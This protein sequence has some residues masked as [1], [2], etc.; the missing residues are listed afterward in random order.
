MEEKGR[1]IENGK[2]G[3]GGGGGEVDISVHPHPPYYSINLQFTSLNDS[4]IEK[5]NGP[6]VIMVYQSNSFVHAEVYQN[7]FF[8]SSG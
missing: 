5:E 3:G 8:I 4:F 2:G 6:C 1:E 7:E